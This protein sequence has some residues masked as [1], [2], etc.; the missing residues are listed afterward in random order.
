MGLTAVEISR[1]LE[2]AT[3]HT[4]VNLFLQDSKSQQDM[5][6]KIHLI[7]VCT[8]PFHPGRSPSTASSDG[9]S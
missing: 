1:F 8:L 3:L 7:A 2:Y 4:H 6:Q 5:L 9:T